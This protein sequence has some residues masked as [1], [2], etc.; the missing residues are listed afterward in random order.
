[1]A[2]LSQ[3]SDADLLSSLPPSPQTFAAQ[4]GPVA[5]DVGQQLGV[6]PKLLLGQWGHET[7]W[8]KSVIPGTNNLGNVKDPT[9]QGPTATDN[10]TGSN[11]SY[12]AFNT[13][14][15]FGR[16]YASLVQ[17]RYPGAVGAGSDVS[18]FTKGLAGYAQDPSYALH[19][20]AAAKSVPDLPSPSPAN[21]GGSNAQPDIS[22][23]SDADL[24]ASLPPS[25]TRNTAQTQYGTVQQQGQPQQPLP[26]Y[27][28]PATPAQPA[29]TMTQQL[30][31][32][33]GLTARDVGHGVADAAG[34]I[35]NPLNATV[36]TIG[37][38]LGYNP[39]LQ[40][41]DT[42]LKNK[43][44]QYTPQPQGALETGVNNVASQLAN[45]LNAMA[46]PIAAGGGVARGALAGAVGAGMQ[47]LHANDTVGG[48]LGSMAGGAATGGALGGAGKVIGGATL[49][50][51]QQ[52]LVD[53]GVNL[54]PGQALGGAAKSFEDIMGKVP[55]AGPAINSAKNAAIDNVNRVLY[56][57]A[58]APIGAKLPDASVVPTGSQGV[59]YVRKAIG[60]VYQ[61]IEPQV[62]FSADTDFINEMNSIRKGLA[63][64]APASLPQF[65]AIVD[66]Q[67]SSK[68]KP[69]NGVMDGAQW[70]DTRSTISDI[71][72]RQ[73]LGVPTPDNLALADSLDDLNGAINQQVFK[74]SPPNVQPAL[75]GANKAWANF[76]QIES[77]AG[78]KAAADNGNIFTPDQF[79]GA[80]RK[81]S[82]ASQRST[83]SGLN[84]GFAQQAKSVVVPPPS[85][86]GHGIGTL[87][88]LGAMDA[89]PLAFA[90][91]HAAM[92]GLGGTAAT[93][94]GLGALFGPT[95]GTQ[96]GRQAMLA[97]LAKR[98]DLLR[99]LGG[100]LSGLAPQV[101]AAAG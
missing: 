100:S 84:A 53:A 26:V 64:N 74:S 15:D 38:A 31:R 90:E 17:N 3:V 92:V 81:G 49:A 16:A 58:L 79:T 69:N 56:Q 4:Y 83:N 2:D 93:L 29:P 33:L 101:G 72:R 94:G 77:A 45:P 91:P 25:A 61:Q 21:G 99:Q 18:K 5:Q 55:V 7:G 68:L 86:G 67:L 78:M 52:A 85:G 73:R 44:D 95:Y 27:G 14:E 51:A 9:G 19:V 89:L 34:V 88:A 65:N 37:K 76:K 36:N 87:L 82:T 54:T 50:P 8:G 42:L 48:Y 39:G 10:A 59:D 98:P 6:D 30:L 71:S 13:P 46:G 22:Q 40:D 80:V 70:G 75:Q 35:G 96:A 47:P 12:Q 97:L 62:K 63:Q 23:L 57:N 60:N 66:N 41:V 1:M 11:D 28:A 20:A 32:Q 24:L 43:I